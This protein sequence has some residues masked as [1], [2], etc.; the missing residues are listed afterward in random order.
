MIRDEDIT[1]GIDGDSCRGT[2]LGKN[3]GAAISF[4][5]IRPVAR[6]GVNDTVR[7]YLADAPVPGVCD[8]EI[9]GCIRSDPVHEL[10]PEVELGRPRGSAI[11]AKRT[12]ARD[13]WDDP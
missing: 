5:T 9:A 3:C 10:E 11:S 1:Q 12:D 8:E 6:D 13:R 4:R 7:S 2:E